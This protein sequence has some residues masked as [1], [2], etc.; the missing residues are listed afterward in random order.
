MWFDKLASFHVRPLPD[1]LGEL[2]L[3]ISSFMDHLFFLGES[4]WTGRMVL[5]GTAFIKN[6][7]FAHPATMVCSKRA[8]RGWGKAA[9][10]FS[11]GPLPWVGLAAI[12]DWLV[13]SRGSLGL[14][15]AR[16]LALQGDGYFRPSELLNIQRSHV[17]TP[18]PRLGSRFKTYAIVVAPSQRDPQDVDGGLHRAAKSGHFDD[19]VLI[20]DKA[21]LEAGRSWVL[22]LMRKLL[23]AASS[24][25]DYLFPCLTLPV[26]ERL[27][28]EATAALGMQRLHATPHSVRHLGASEDSLAG[29]RTMGQIQGRGRWQA[30]AS[31]ARYS[32]HARLLRQVAALPNPVVERGAEV[33]GRATAVLHL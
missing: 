2:D 28:S 33:L 3:A 15:A 16:A 18:L 23:K 27:F 5:Y 1:D 20:G 9:P 13:E 4:Q 17:T 25:S 29:L 21:S 14:Q 8:L 31:V 11:R 24:P 6:L 30:A 22:P 10:E 12:C 26:L 19:T 7:S 32:K